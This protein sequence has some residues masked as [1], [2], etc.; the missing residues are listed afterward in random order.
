M[1][2]WLIHLFIKDYA[3]VEDPEVRASYGTL[4]SVTGVAVNLLLAGAKL[5]LGLISGSLAVMADAANNL[6]DAAGSIVTLI[7]TRLA[8]KPVD[9]EHPFGHGR[10]E[11]IGSLAVGA[12]IVVMGVNLLRDGISAILHPQPLAV[13]WIVVVILSASILAKLWLFFFYRRLGNAIHNGTLLAASKDSLG[14]VL[15]TGAVLISLLIALLFDVSADGYIGVVV[16]AIVF[17]SGVDVCRDTVDSLLGGKPDPEKIRRIRELL[18]SHE[19][20]LGIHDLVLHDYGPGRC[21]ASVHAEV[22]AD[23][24]IVAIHEVIDDAEREISRKLHMAICI[25]MD[26][27]VT[28][29]ENVNRVHR[30]L[31]EFL[32][33]ID[34]AL[35]LH[36]FRMVPGQGHINVIFD[37]VLPPSYEGRDELLKSLNAYAHSLDERYHL[38]VQFDTDFT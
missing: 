12:L 32:T 16:A 14:D 31:S 13:S 19:G 7:T 23:S 11:Y 10:M 37:C 24:D 21:I 35:S 1:S 18:L 6:S 22:S 30:Q 33:S 15:S 38:V 34:P 8:K 27:I 9:H 28:N 17:K 20:I 5:F 29:D 3:N 4:G 26:P 2:T 36:D 25:H